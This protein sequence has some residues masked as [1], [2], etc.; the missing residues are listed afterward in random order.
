M[1]YWYQLDKTT[2]RIVRITEAVIAQL[3]AACHKRYLA[4]AN[5]QLI[6]AWHTQFLKELEEGRIETDQTAYVR[7]DLLTKAEMERALVLIEAA[8][9]T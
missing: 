6:A 7:E 9:S 5:D 4:N 3:R 1:T 2:G 8:S